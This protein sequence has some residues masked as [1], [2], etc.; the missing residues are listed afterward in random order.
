VPPPP[1]KKKQQL[2]LAALDHKTARNTTRNSRTSCL[3]YLSASSSL[4]VSTL[5]PLYFRSRSSRS[6]CQWMRWNDGRQEALLISG[7]AD[8]ARTQR[9]RP[10]TLQELSS[11]CWEPQLLPKNNS[12]S[13]YQLFFV[14]NCWEPQ[15]ALVSRGIMWVSQ[16][17][18][19]QC[20]DLPL[21]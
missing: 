7:S 5:P 11:S 12:A 6:R 17:C 10:P 16:L 9:D 15:G 3:R 19:M 2:Y 8:K 20:V 13:C 1:Q 4:G 14:V 21:I 18:G